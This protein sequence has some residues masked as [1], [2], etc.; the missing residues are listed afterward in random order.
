MMTTAQ[1]VAVNTQEIRGEIMNKLFSVLFVSMFVCGIAQ[2]EDVVV[3]TKKVCKSQV[4]KDGKV[5]KNKDG[6]EKQ[7]CKT[8]KIHKKHEGTAVPVKK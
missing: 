8:I 4:G 1:Y 3:P 6:S 5:V 2:A 7:V